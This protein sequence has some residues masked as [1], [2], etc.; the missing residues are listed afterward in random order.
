M[1]G[2]RIRTKMQSINITADSLASDLQV[3]P[4]TISRLIAGNVPTVNWKLIEQVAK[5]LGWSVSDLFDINT[6]APSLTGVKKIDEAITLFFD[7]IFNGSEGY[8]RV[9]HLEGQTYEIFF[10]SADY[11][12]EARRIG[13]KSMREEFDLNARQFDPDGDGS[14]SIEVTLH[15]A[16][17]TGYARISIYLTTSI[18]RILKAEDIHLEDSLPLSGLRIYKKSQELIDNWVLDKSIEKIKNGDSIKIRR[19]WLSTIKNRNEYLGQG[20][21]T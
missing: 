17:V 21:Q 8:N 11:S 10:A 19:R 7:N 9:R 13:V 18:I 5:K 14:K 16:D 20:I 1:V 4:P 6:I 3:S 15:S 12:D 2:D